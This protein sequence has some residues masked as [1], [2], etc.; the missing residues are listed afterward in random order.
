M[1]YAEGRTYHDADS[2]VVETPDWFFGFADPV[3][4]D[5]M[6]ALYVS[7]VKPGEELFTVSPAAPPASRN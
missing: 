6:E 1:P 5:R 4:R 2:H 7:T 3:I